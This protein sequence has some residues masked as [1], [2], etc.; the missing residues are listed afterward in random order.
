MVADKVTKIINS[1]LKRALQETRK[2]TTSRRGL[3]GHFRQLLE[4]TIQTLTPIE[5]TLI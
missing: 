5:K 3:K 1:I 2:M 4:L